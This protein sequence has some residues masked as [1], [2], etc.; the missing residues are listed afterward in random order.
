MAKNC[1]MRARAVEDIEKGLSPST[2]ED[3]T[4]ATFFEMILEEQ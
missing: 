3:S 4:G 2:S 1:K